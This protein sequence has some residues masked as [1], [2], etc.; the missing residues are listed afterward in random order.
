MR[1]CYEYSCQ[2]LRLLLYPNG[3]ATGRS[4]DLQSTIVGSNPTRGKS[5]VTTLVKLFIPPSPSSITWYRP[6]GGDAL[7][8]GR[9][10]QAWR[11]VMAAYH[12]VD[13]CGLTAC[14]P[15]SAL[16]RMLGSHTFTL[17]HAVYCFV[18]R[19][20]WASC[21]TLPTYLLANWFFV[22][23]LERKVLATRHT[24]T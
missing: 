21:Q 19:I 17:L 9:L 4:L 8:L 18:S 13:N 20:C 5:C 15:G 10:P 11:K 6:R 7:R 1:R 2:R 16:G 12:R 14:T 22:L 3:G 23:T 24:V